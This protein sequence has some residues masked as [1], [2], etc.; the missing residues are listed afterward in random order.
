M[1]VELIPKSLADPYLKQ[2]Q[3]VRVNSDAFASDNLSKVDDK[4]IRFCPYLF[5]I[6]VLKGIEVAQI[7]AGG[8]TSFVR[9]PTGRVLGWGANEHGQVGLGSSVSLDTITVP[10]E[11]IL[12]RFVRNNVQSKCL[13]VVAGG[14]LTGFVVERLSEQGP[15]TTDLLMC[16]NGQYGGLG[17]NTFTNNQGNPSRVKAVSSLLQYND[18]KQ[19]LEAIQPDEISISHTGHILLS[20]ASNPEISGVGGRDLLVWGRNNESELGNGKR[21]N[22]VFPTP[23]QSPD[24]HERFML[25]EK[26]AK[27]VKDLA[28]VVWKRGVKVRQQVV[29]GFNN[30]MVYWKI[31][32]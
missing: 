11:V 28:G 24:E 29:S 2:S 30:S 26:K 5:E 10:T 27:E 19:G 8:R 12:W 31:V 14:D 15:N 25:R 1:N 16:G 6:P 22:A 21:S 3:A 23:V 7:A 32:N 13:N 4:P 18:A 20:L 17:N 9:T